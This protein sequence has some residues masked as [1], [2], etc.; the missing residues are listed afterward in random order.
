MVAHSIQ[1]GVLDALRD[2]AFWIPL[3]E[4]GETTSGEYS[5]WWCGRR[6]YSGGCDIHRFST[7][8]EQ[9]QE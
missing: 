2:L 4:T 5:I 6:D 1:F 7:E 9:E 3:N 8:A